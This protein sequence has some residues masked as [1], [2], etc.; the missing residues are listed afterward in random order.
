VSSLGGTGSLKDPSGHASTNEECSIFPRTHISLRSRHSSTAT[1]LSDLVDLTA[2][3]TGHITDPHKN[4]S[5][6]SSSSH[7]SLL[8]ARTSRDRDVR[9][10]C[11]EKLAPNK[12]LRVA[13]EVC[14]VV[15]DQQV[16]ENPP[17]GSSSHDPSSTVETL[18]SK[19]HCPICFRNYRR[20]IASS[21]EFVE[22]K[23]ETTELRVTRCGHVFCRSCIVSY[24][25]DRKTCAMCKQTLTLRQVFPL[26]L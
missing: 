11:C 2:P 7:W 21:I 8:A 17:T 14:L 22:D 12:R 9:G 20:K 5:S 3:C 23:D 15:D 6:S 25:Q 1:T 26:Y 16:D 18:L 24:V 4:T 10:S 19:L 13:Q